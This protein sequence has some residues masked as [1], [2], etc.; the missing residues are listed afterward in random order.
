MLK[1]H[2]RI[3]GNAFRIS[4]K[5]HAGFDKAGKD[6]VCAAVSALTYT[7]IQALVDQEIEPDSYRDD[8][9][10]FY[11]SAKLNE[12]AKIAV[13]TIL[14]GYDLLSSAYPENILIK[15]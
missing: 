10:D 8:P 9:G 11:L 7:M 2:P 1:I 3:N 6:I 14:R 5:G 15:K 4:V 13:Q 12:P